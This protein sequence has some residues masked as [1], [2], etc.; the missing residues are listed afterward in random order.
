MRTFDLYGFNSK[1][2]EGTAKEVAECLA[3]EFASHDSSYRGGAYYRSGKAGSEEFILQ[4]NLDFMD[5]E[6]IEASFPEY[7]LLLYV[8]PT[9]RSDEIRQLFSETFGSRAKLL[10][11]ELL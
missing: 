2:L 9:M 6:P 4:R 5:S 11:H 10:R 3:I 1:D 8:G 7:P